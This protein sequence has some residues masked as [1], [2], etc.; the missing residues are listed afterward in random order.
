MVRHFIILSSSY[1]QGQR[2]AL[3]MVGLKK[4]NIDLFYQTVEKI[5]KECGN[6]TSI[7]IHCI[8]ASSEMWNSVVAEDSFFEDVFVVKTVDEFIRVIQ[9]DRTLSGL[10]IAKYILSM[11]SCT[12]LKLQKLAYYCFADYLCT[13]REPLFQDK[14]YAFNLGP[15]VKSIREKFKGFRYINIDNVD[16]ISDISPLN[17]PIR[18]KILFADKGISKLKSIE[19][20]IDK[21]GKCTAGELVDLTHKKG[22]PWDYAYDGSSFKIIPNEIILQRHHLEL[23]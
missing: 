13:A 20:T 1:S 9:M 17:M 14:I 3:D 18:S 6:D 23:I 5:K 19:Q 11:Q 16:M 7:S 8:E 2:I 10:D 12:H 22:A 21:Y 15:V 4:N